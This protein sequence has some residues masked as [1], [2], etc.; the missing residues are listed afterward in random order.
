[1]KQSSFPQE[2][3]FIPFR[4]VNRKLYFEHRSF[5]TR[6]IGGKSIITFL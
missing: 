5:E 6:N 4:D 3:L 2:V 1:M